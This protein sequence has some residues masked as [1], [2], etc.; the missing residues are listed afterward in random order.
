MKNIVVILCDQIRKDYL[1]IYGSEAI[2][3]PNLANLASDGII[4]DNAIT[5]SPVCA[6]AR[7]SMIT[8]RYVSDHNVWT[9]DVP[10][11]DGLKYLPVAMNELGYTTGA[12]GKL[13]HFPATD[14][15]GFSTSMLM[16]EN[17]LGQNEPFIKFLNEKNI[18]CKNVFDY[19]N[20][21]DC[22]YEEWIA[23]NAI[24]FINENSNKPFFAW[25]S[26]QGPHDPFDAP[27]DCN[28]DINLSKL[29]KIA[30]NI[31]Q[32]PDVVL[33]RK[34][35]ANKK[36]TRKEMNK[37]L[38]DYAKQIPIIDYEIGKIIKKLKEL[39]LYDNTAIIFSAD[40]GEMLGDYGLYAKGPFPYSN[41]L[42]IPLILANASND[43]NVRNDK[44][45]SNIDIPS[46]VLD[47]AKSSLK[48]GHSQSL[49]SNINR[50]WNFSEFC[51]S[52]K[53]V[54]NKTFR[55]CYFGLTKQSL[56]HKKPNEFINLSDNNEY[57]D[58]ECECLKQLILFLSKINIKDNTF[59]LETKYNAKD[60]EGLK[61]IIDKIIV[62]N[63]V[64]IEAHDL[65]EKIHNRLNLLQPDWK[66]NIKIVFP[67]SAKWQLRA[68][69]KAK[70]SRKIN[71]FC[72]GRK[73]IA[74]YGVY[75]KEKRKNNW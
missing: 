57:L 2:P 24:N 23:N 27:K 63:G 59:D 68:I 14:T 55:Y 3:T 36:L 4:F 44:L 12:F 46:T 9:N 48:L 39:N 72:K 26:F 37:R 10:F 61:D 53:I 50:E 32:M 29:P 15:K 73:R 8:G 56:L 74:D 69:K 19:G 20:K 41:Q 60:K 31:S 30:E 16:E 54:E 21:L 6:P 58:I 35:F 5:A 11:R 52:A 18:K 65:V 13:H 17:R 51:D 34:A 45:V 62:A 1:Q 7:A 47:I 33:N 25:V 38:I 22:Y 71:E 40:H 70:L 42:N 64:R 75:W 28:F 43:K 49:I 67:L 66:D